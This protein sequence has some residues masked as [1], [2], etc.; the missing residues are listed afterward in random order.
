LRQLQIQEK[1]KKREQLNRFKKLQK[2][3]RTQSAFQISEDKYE[4]IKLANK[5]PNNQRMQQYKR[6]LLEKE[7][8][9]DS[10]FQKLDYQSS[11]SG[12]ASS[13]SGTRHQ[14]KK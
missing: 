11:S 2:P 9:T 13:R 7:E 4:M 6:K 10:K 14:A 12:F 8:G 1:Y 5:Y 3:M